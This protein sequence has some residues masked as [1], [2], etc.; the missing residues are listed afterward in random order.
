MT[1]R[2]KKIAL[3]AAVSLIGLC[4]VVVTVSFIVM[5]TQWFSDQVRSKFVSAVE[6]STGGTVE[7]GS[8]QLD[9][10][11]LTVRIRDLV[12]HGTEPK[13]AAPLA[14]IS[15]IE[16]RL[17][18][19]SGFKN[20][21]DLAYLGVE[22]P[23]VSITI[24]ADGSTNIPEPKVKKQSNGSPLE[25]VVNL[26]VGQFR[27]ERGL[28]AYSE[29][30][31]PI[32][33]QGE[34]LR[35]LLQYVGTKQSYQGNVRIDPL[36]IAYGT[37]PPLL[38]H[39]DLPLELKKDAVSLTNAR[40]TTVLSQIRLNASVAR[41]NSPQ[42]AVQLSAQLSASELAASF[43]MPVATS[44]PAILY[45]DVNG[46]FDSQAKTF[47]LPRMH[48]ALGNTTLDASGQGPTVNFNANL[49][50]AEMSRL[51]KASPPQ[52]TGELVMGGTASADI[53]AGTIHSRGLALR[54]GSTYLADVSISTP[55]H[56]TSHAVS[57]DQL[58][59][60]VLGGSITASVLI[61]ELRKLTVKGDLRG[62][63][64]PAISS[65]LTGRSIGYDGKLAGSISAK[66]DLKAKGTS[67]VTAGASLKITPGQHGIPVTGSLSATYSGADGLI[68]LNRSYL[69]LPH[70]RVDVS[71]V[72]GRALNVVMKSRNLNDF[73]PLTNLSSGTPLKSLPVNVEGRGIANISASVKG[74]LRHA[75]ISANATMTD[76]TVRASPFERF[77]LDISAS[78]YGVD[79]RNGSL[80]KQGITSAF[81]ASLGLVEWRPH[82]YS[83]VS[84]NLTLN[85]AG[86]REL[87]ALAGTD[88]KIARGNVDSEVRIT[89]TYG[90]PLGHA[91]IHASAGEAY[92]QQYERVD[93]RV[94]LSDRLARLDTLEI[95][96]AGG[97]LSANASFRHPL[98]TVTSGHAEVQLSTNS[99]QLSAV[100]AVQQTSPG[101]AGV[102]RCIAKASADIANESEKTSLTIAN[103]D[104]DLSAQALRVRG[105]DA[106]A[107]T[108][109]AHTTGGNVIY[110]IA[111]D[112]AG[113][114]VKVQGRTALSTGHYT[115]AS[116]VI[117]NLSL[118]KALDL[119]NQTAVPVSGILSASAQVDGSLDSPDVAVNLGLTK[120]VVYQEPIDRLTA[121]IHYN[122]RLLDI[123]SIDLHAPAGTLKLSGRYDHDTDIR[124]GLLKVHISDSEFQLAKIKHAQSIEPGIA[125][126]LRL[127]ADISARVDSQN[128]SPEILA[129]GVSA[130]ISGKGL[131]V[132]NRSL[133]ALTLSAHTSSS[134]VIFQFDSDLVGSQIHASGESQ[135]TRNYPTRANITFKNVRYENVSP[136]LDSESD[137]P[138]F[139]ALVE[140]QAS[141]N[142]PLLDVNALSARLEISSLDLRT[143]SRNTPT[144][145]PAAR[146]AEFQNQ[147][148]IVVTL[149]KSVAAIDQM[150]IRGP[151]AA[152][153]VSGSVDLAN[154]ASPLK[155]SVNAKGD[156]SVL[157]NVSRSFYSS[158][159]V[160]ANFVVGGTFADPLLNGK[161]ELHNANIN[162]ASVPNGISNSNGVV[163]LNG[164]TATIQNLTAE[165]GGGK[166]VISGFAGLSPSAVIYNVRARATKVRTR[167]GDAS[168]TTTANLALTGDSNHSILAG[169]VSVQRVAYSSSSDIGSL[170]YT[171]ALPP[172]STAESSS[173]LANMQ[174]DI[175]VVTASD[176]RVVT[177][178]VEKLNLTGSLYVRGTAAEPSVT[179]KITFTDGQLA[180]FGNTYDVRKGSINFYDTTAIRPVLDL[181]LETVTQG[182]DVVLGV[183]GPVSDMKLSYRSDPPLTF[184]QI[185][186]LLATNTTPFDATIASQQPT[187]PPQSASQLGASAVL[188]QAVAN[189]L[190][191]RVQR[192]FGLSE[193][194]IDPSIAGSGGQPSARV[195]LQQKIANN[196]TFTYITDVTQTDSEIVK[197]ELDL[198]SKT[199]A[200]ALRDYNGNVSVELFYK[201]QV[202]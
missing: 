137:A 189:P 63:F 165:S 72:L 197:V 18:L 126:T 148:P 188:G 92:G 159:T 43:G 147:G 169:L 31:D 78:P 48:I 47:A 22:E 75:R 193:F 119:A 115:K 20:I 154:D 24:N 55:F 128:G 113:S 161:V 142:G 42:V 65:A 93:A 95:A 124:H 46:S 184:D 79:I 49:A 167:Y 164:T 123:P 38:V 106:G 80:S 120:A 68:D 9:V 140:G 138:P 149:N 32:N 3:T 97:T 110:E 54:D 67:G 34:N 39:V 36:R 129:T 199:S 182:V 59:V 117:G 180:F 91:T 99:L 96:T 83:P 90:N 150:H 183:T 122:N 194:K 173:L 89:G 73:L 178:Y 139:N 102:V 195:T 27:I 103:I 14:R 10:S 37:Q 157:Q 107:L 177:S 111:S 196:L 118:S 176:V 71:G 29:R 185:V 66:A 200:V 136:F 21:V 172:S 86:V 62:F 94:N 144:G 170:L 100:D 121:T 61:E 87:L 174:L 57:L 186:Q 23:R 143:N 60:Y 105:R 6:D 163:L 44:T 50:L 1:A 191:S 84:F 26:A 108:A 56:V 13:T 125:G 198:N 28:I 7:I 77:A 135:L 114:N 74:D 53:L 69:V 30:K 132:A 19:L 109:S 70:S 51:F 162:Y 141:L 160:A 145:G 104:L 98:G 187:T 88:D 25:T 11:R 85:H 146:T 45:A 5:Q 76:F 35:V 58:K 16:L 15:L 181:S 2:R 153:D 8:F 192:V 17:K 202:H 116:A 155:L 130:D 134:K 156:L 179:G 41:L 166:I 40:L 190:A 52:I 33:L 151:E 175:H 12:L 64:L 171:S 131:Q 168:V 158:G 81:D 133:G 82:G 201:F 152:M 127:A 4:A 112:F 101:S